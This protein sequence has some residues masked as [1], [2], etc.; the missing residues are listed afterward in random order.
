MQVGNYNLAYM[1]IFDMQKGSVFTYSYS[2]LC[3]R[4]FVD[5]KIQS[6]YEISSKVGKFLGNCAYQ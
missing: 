6:L 3:A 1:Y 2:M 4:V 5:I